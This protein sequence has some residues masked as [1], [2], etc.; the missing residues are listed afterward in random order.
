M[1]KEIFTA[2]GAEQRAV[3][4]QVVWSARGNPAQMA[5]LECSVFEVFFGG[6]RGGGKTD[7]M[8]G[9]F[10]KHGGRY[11]KHAIGLMIRRTRTELIETIERSRAIYTPLGW[12]YNETDKM[13]RA[14][15]DA[16]LRF[17]YLERDADA[18]QYQ[19]HSYT[20]LYVEE[21]GNFPSPA[22]IFK[23]MATLRSSAGVPVG[24]RATG[25]PGGPGHQWVK[26]RYIDPAPLGNR[27]I[28]EQ[29]GLKRVF[30][31]S[32]VDNN[33]HIDVE[34]YKQNLRA[35]GSK[36][37]VSAWLDGDWSV[38]LGAFFDCWS[39]KR[40]VVKPFEVPQEWTRFRSMDWGSASPFSI[41]WW[42]VVQDDFETDGRVLPRG[43]LVRYR[44]W[45]GCKPGQP[46]TGIKLHA[47]NVGMGIAARE[48]D[49]KIA[50]G[51][52]DPSAFAEDGG[53]SIAERIARTSANKVHFRRADNRR[54]AG[55]G[56]IGGWDQLRARLVGDGA[57]RA[58]I[59]TFSTCA[60]SIRTVPFLQHDPDRPED[61]MT[62]SEDHAAD[63]WRYACMSRPYVRTIEKPKPEFPSGYRPYRSSQPGDWLTY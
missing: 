1:G 56:A 54:V 18:D 51:V 2:A 31:P 11:G 29:T 62:D 57:G 35:S 21:I 36:E 48:K 27:I 41:G 4:Q 17:A 59:V 22:P 58:M 30:I 28:R 34:A 46:N 15:N 19:G 7:G 53:P 38:T 32:K 39:A 14:P 40:H 55:H 43:C 63:E 42:A 9:E 50:Y 33:R 60:D 26:A 20:R 25:N 8:L 13:W 3:D 10:T 61:V 5:L 23:L 6:A 47:D 24:F 45:Y 44:E 37:L 16:R 52:L 12:K 49:E